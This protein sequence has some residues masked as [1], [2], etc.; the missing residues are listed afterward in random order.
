MQLYNSNSSFQTNAT[1][2]V[3]FGMSSNSAKLFGMLST[4][5]YSDKEK[6]VMY[7]I[8]ANCVDAHAL[9]GNQDEPWD[10]VCP[11]ALS[12]YIKFRDYGPGLSTEQVYNLLANYGESTKADSNE[13]IGAFGIGA[14]SPVAVTS[15]WTVVSRYQ[16]TESHFVVFVGANGIPAIT[17][18]RD[19]PTDE[20]SGLEIIIPVSPNKFTSWTNKIAS[21]FEQYKVKPNVINFAVSWPDMAKTV[22]KGDN[23]FILSGNGSGL[24]AITTQRRY[25]LDVNAIKL[26]VDEKK[27]NTLISFGATINF[28]TGELETS[29]SRESIQY[30]AHTI[31][32]ISTRV[33][34]AITEL[35]KYAD[36]YMSSAT[37][38][39][40]YRKK[41]NELTLKFYNHL[42]LLSVNNILRLLDNVKYGIKSHDDVHSFIIS[43]KDHEN[44]KF[45][46]FNGKSSFR[47]VKFGFNCGGSYYICFSRISYGG[48]SA[49]LS[50][51]IDHLGRIPV[52]IADD[53]HTA[54]KIKHAYPNRH[55][56]VSEHNIF[57]P[58]M[59]KYVVLAS[60]LAS[61]PRATVARRKPSK[62]RVFK[63]LPSGRLVRVHDDDLNSD[64][65]YIVLDKDDNYDDVDTVL[66]K[67]TS[68]ELYF[69]RSIE[70]LPDGAELLK[71]HF[72]KMVNDYNTQA[73]ANKL[74]ARMV[75]NE[76]VLF[77]GENSRACKM[78]AQNLDQP[79]TFKV[80]E[81]VRTNVNEII[82]TYKSS[83]QSL[84]MYIKMIEC[85]NALC[86]TMKSPAT[87]ISLDDINR[88][89]YNAYPLLKF[90]NSEIP[91]NELFAYLELTGN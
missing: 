46:F 16:G 9:N 76:F 51:R 62:S 14:K 68:E 47:Q 37:D 33:D 32:N 86:I 21:V 10:L 49:D 85:A 69:I 78:L 5:L 55:V 4:S 2:Q 42:S 41:I 36:D 29:L 25:A 70:N 30:T 48:G 88:M 77:K 54:A 90:V 83:S 1:T 24:F 28:P 45:R 56:F 39:L 53:K 17:M 61:P 72:T 50:F 35:K 31:K 3:Q 19:L 58:E 26:E 20:P 13:Y 40:D 27:L 34:L 73:T 80:F 64:A 59:Q 84:D 43:V 15:D 81:K 79:T 38:G 65:L 6:A 87:L 60:S 18:I 11:T 66:R 22:F 67:H 74:A 71:D 12:P 82:D 44:E 7:E 8:G 91:Q 57:P 52:V 75:Y 63:E 23:L 89:M